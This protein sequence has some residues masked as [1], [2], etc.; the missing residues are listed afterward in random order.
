MVTTGNHYRIKRV[1]VNMSIAQTKSNVKLK[2]I[3]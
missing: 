2:S 1:N 3:H